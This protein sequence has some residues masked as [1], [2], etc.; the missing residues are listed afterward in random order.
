MIITEEVILNEIKQLRKVHRK[1]RKDKGVKRPIYTQSNNKKF[2]S[3]LKR[4][5]AKGFKFELL[6]SDFEILNELDCH[7]CGDLASGY[8][9]V[10]SKIGYIKSNIVPACACCNMMKNSANVKNFLYQIKKIHNHLNL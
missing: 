8:D 6:E 1:M 2:L 9:R 5:N 10:D 3:Y 4:A 7:Y